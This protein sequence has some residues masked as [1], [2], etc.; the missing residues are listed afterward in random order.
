MASAWGNVRD[1]CEIMK[2]YLNEQK[3]DLTYL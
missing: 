2:T 3:F 1:F